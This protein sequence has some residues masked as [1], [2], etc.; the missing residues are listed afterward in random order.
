[1]KP[2]PIRRVSAWRGIVWLAYGWAVGNCG[3]VYLFRGGS[4][5]YRVE[6]AALIFV[7]VLLP[8]LA[9]PPGSVS[10]PRSWNRLHAMLL[11]GLAAAL[12]LSVLGRAI[13]LPFLNDDYVFLD[14]YRTAGQAFS[15]PYFFRPVFAWTFWVAHRVGGGSV[16]PF[17]ILGLFLHAASSACVYRL[18]RRSLD[19]GTAAAIAAAIFLMNPLQLEVSLWPSGLQDGLWTFFVLAATVVYTWG[20]EITVARL[21]ATALLAALALLSKET[22]VSFVLILLLAD[23]SVSSSWTRMRYVAYGIFLLEL[24]AYLWTRSHFAIAVDQQ[25][26]AVAPTRYFLKQFVTTPYR[27]FMFPWNAAATNVPGPIACVIATALLTAAFRACQPPVR[28]LLLGPGLILASTLPLAGYFYV[29]ADLTAARYVYFA[30]AGWSLLVAE[31][32][33]R[34]WRARL[35]QWSCAAV[36]VVALFLALRVNVRPWRSAGEFVHDLDAGLDAGR[37]TSEIV[38]EWHA[39]NGMSGALNSDDIPKSYRGV[40]I[41]TNGYSE[42]VRLRSER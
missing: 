26:A 32:V 14:R 13:A 19:S 23:L 3:Y 40:H 35:A 30:A 9:M 2:A 29:G 31:C 42:Y 10:G 20:A 27:V 5:A 28:P 12:W 1:M 11:L 24:V 17:H 22:A 38:R 37:T 18:A 7:A 15:S 33:T 8:S 21:A 16:I 41:F 4:R 6:S 36:I 39:R 25:L 34:L